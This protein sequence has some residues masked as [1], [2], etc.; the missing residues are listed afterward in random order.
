MLCGFMNRCLRTFYGLYDQVERNEHIL[1]AVTEVLSLLKT[2]VVEEVG[3]ANKSVFVRFGENRVEI[4]PSGNTFF[5]KHLGVSNPIA[6]FGREEE[7]YFELWHTEE[8]R[9]AVNV[10][11]GF[12][13]SRGNTMVSFPVQPL[14]QQIW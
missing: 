13:G 8:G 14:P 5:I 12:Q 9:T 4:Y 2:G 10:V 3:P 11:L 7:T 6:E 1:F